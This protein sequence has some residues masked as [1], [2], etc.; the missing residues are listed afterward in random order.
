[1]KDSNVRRR[2]IAIAVSALILG[3][4]SALVAGNAFAGEEPSPVQRCEDQL[5]RHNNGDEISQ[6][7]FDHCFSD[8]ANSDFANTPDHVQRCEDQQ[9]LFKNGD[10]VHLTTFESC[11]LKP[12]IKN[13]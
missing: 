6:G 4:G 3:S 9:M 13:S 5:L 8:K 12:E 2:R 10:K 1:M 11:F 7:T